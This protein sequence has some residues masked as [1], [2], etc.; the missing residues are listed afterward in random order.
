MIDKERICSGGLGLAVP[1]KIM[2]HIWAAEGI[3]GALG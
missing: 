1:A 2:R 3:V